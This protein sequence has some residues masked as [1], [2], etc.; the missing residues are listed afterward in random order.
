MS[1]SRMINGSFFLILPMLPL[2][3]LFIS[4]FRGGKEGWNHVEVKERMTP[5]V[6][7]AERPETEPDGDKK[8]FVF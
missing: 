1:R 4:N 5:V 6:H 2:L 7:H 8:P 3:F